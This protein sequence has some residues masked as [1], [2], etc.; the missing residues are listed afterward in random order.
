[1]IAPL[2]KAKQPHVLTNRH[3]LTDSDRWSP[4]DHFFQNKLKIDKPVLE[5]ISLF[6]W[7]L[8]KQ[9]FC[10]DKKKNEC[11]YVRKLRELLSVK[12]HSN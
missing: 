1:M 8:G 9:E 2:N 7:L 11:I 6:L 10:M 4:K 5:E 12:F 3:G